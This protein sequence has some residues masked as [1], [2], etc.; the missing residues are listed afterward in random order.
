MEVAVKLSPVFDFSP[1][2]KILD[3]PES[4]NGFWD[5]SPDGKRFI[6]GVTKATDL[7][8]SQVNIVVGWFEELK[9]KLAMTTR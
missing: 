9:K 5:A 4:W 7:M 8:P 2:K 1:P 6:I 3:L